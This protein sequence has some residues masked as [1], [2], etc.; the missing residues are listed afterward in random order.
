MK[1]YHELSAFPKEKKLESKTEVAEFVLNRGSKFV[2][3]V[4]HTVW[5]M[6]DSQKTLKKDKSRLQLL[7]DFLDQECVPDFHG[8]LVTCAKKVLILQQYFSVQ[9]RT[10]CSHFVK[11]RERKI[12]NKTIFIIIMIIIIIIIIIIIGSPAFRLG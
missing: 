3:E 6:E 5:D 4:L 8:R 9:L 1:S 11:K 12:A 2:A 7:Y 10:V